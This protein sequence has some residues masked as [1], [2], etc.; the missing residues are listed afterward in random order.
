MGAR[1]TEPTSLADRLEDRASITI[2]L[3]NRLLN[4]EKL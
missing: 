2:K 3:I 4:D 1:E